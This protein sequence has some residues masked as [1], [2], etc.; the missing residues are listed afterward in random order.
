MQ[1]LELHNQLPF[2]S[3]EFLYSAA[4][5]WIFGTKPTYFNIFT[6]AQID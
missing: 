5:S 4:S 6:T 1:F 2:H 3:A